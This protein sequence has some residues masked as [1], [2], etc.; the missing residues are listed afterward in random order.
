MR[1]SYT[2]SSTIPYPYMCWPDTQHPL[3]SVL[4]LDPPSGRRGVVMFISNH[5]HW[6]KKYMKELMKYIHID[7]Y[8]KTFHNTDMH[9]SRGRG[10][11]DFLSVK[12]HLIKEKGYKFLI[13]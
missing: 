5:E 7:S 11:S 10:S 8:G 2:L 3:L 6:R 1:V 9:S 13:T 4:K 12:L